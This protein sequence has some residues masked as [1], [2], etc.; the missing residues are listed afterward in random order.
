MSDVLTELLEEQGFA[1]KW[2]AATVKKL[3][4]QVLKERTIMQPGA[5]FRYLQTE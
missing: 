3:R 4:E 5:V 2:K 1:E